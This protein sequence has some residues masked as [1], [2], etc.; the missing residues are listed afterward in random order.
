[1]FGDTFNLSGCTDG[2]FIM[3]EAE[4]SGRNRESENDTSIFSEWSYCTLLYSS[5]HCMKTVTVR[6][7]GRRRKVLYAVATSHRRITIAG[8]VCG[9]E[10]TLHF[11]SILSLPIDFYRCQT[12]KMT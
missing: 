2:C 4:E 9:V 12:S 3:V 8:F 1:M 10:E 11:D 5:V 6:L 7:L